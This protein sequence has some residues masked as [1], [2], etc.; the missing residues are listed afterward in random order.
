MD[1][2]LARLDQAIDKAIV[3][4]DE[5]GRPV[6]TERVAHIVRSLKRPEEVGRL[7]NTYRPGFF[8]IG[9]ADDDEPQINYLR[10]EIGLSNDE[11]YAILERDQREDD[12][13]GQR[14]STVGSFLRRGFRFRQTKACRKNSLLFSPSFSKEP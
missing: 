12:P 5:D 1:Q 13:H 3:E 7:R 14:T 2:L 11:A 8:L 4:D 10:K 9:I 6:A